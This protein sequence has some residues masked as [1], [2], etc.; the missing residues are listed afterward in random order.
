MTIAPVISVVFLSEIQSASCGQAS[1]WIPDYY[2]GDD[3]PSLT[4]DFEDDVL[5]QA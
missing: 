4:T 1:P 5:P 2:L 3:D